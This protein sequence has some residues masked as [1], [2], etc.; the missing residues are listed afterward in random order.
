M[1]RRMLC[2]FCTALIL[3]GAVPAFSETAAKS[4]SYDFDLTFHLNA[5]SFPELLR[6]RAEGYASLVNCLGLRGTLSWSNET[7]SMDLEATLYFIGNPSLSYPFRLYGTKSRLFLTSPMINNEIILLNMSALMEFAI[8]AKNTLGVPL[9]YFALLFP[10]TTE[11]AFSGFTQAWRNV[12]GTLKEDGE[13]TVDQ[14]REVADLWT[15]E[16]LNNG[17]LHWWITGVAGG[18]DATSAVEAEINNLP[19]YYEN[20]TGG[21]PVSVSVAPGSET[22]KNAAGDTLFSRQ[23]SD[24]SMCMALALPASEN[25]YIPSF[26]SAY[27]LQ[28]QMLSFEVAASVRRDTSGASGSPAEEKVDS[29]DDTG[30]EED[31]DEAGS[32]ADEEYENDQDWELDPENLPE[33]MLDFH[34]QGSGLPCILPCDSSFAVSVSV[35]GALYPDYAFSFTGETKKDGAVTLSLSKPSDGTTVPVEIFRCSGTFVPSADPKSVPDYSR[36]DLEGVYN[37]FSFNENK[38]AAFNSKVLPP[39]VRSIFT[40]VAAAPTS[41]CQSFLDDLTDIGI[42]DMLID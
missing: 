5:D 12:I 32:D 28:D 4:S 42:L 6:T 14:F 10:Y 1:F 36:K 11:S 41:A 20:V 35:Q 13:V 9:T 40:F 31:W 24:G 33:L 27:Q 3:A 39:L 37:V 38:L 26:S 17:L 23:E 8:K 21:L 29:Y 15:N 7:Q 22:W 30:E 18:S 19:G 16:L 34:A 25:G 2:L